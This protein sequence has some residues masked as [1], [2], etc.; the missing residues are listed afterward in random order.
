MKYRFYI[1]VLTF[2][3]C[4]SLY[5]QNDEQRTDTVKG[6][7]LRAVNTESFV[8]I[9]DG[10]DYVKLYREEKERH[11]LL[12]EKLKILKERKKSLLYIT[13]QNGERLEKE[14]K[15]KNKELL[16]KQQE[17]T[18]VITKRNNSELPKLMLELERLEVSIKSIE[19]DT[20]K[21]SN[22]LLALEKELKHYNED[23]TKLE[24]VKEK[25]VDRLL[26][27]NSSYLEN[28]FIE[29]TIEGLQRIKEQCRKYATD[30][31]VNAL[32]ARTDKVLKNKIIYDSTKQVIES[33]YDKVA[34]SDAL[35]DIQITE[36]INDVQRKDLSNVRD[37]LKMYEQ[38]LNAFKEFISEL[39][40]KRAGLSSYTIRDYNDDL[41][42]I[43]SRNNLE[44]RIKKY[45]L[46]VPYLSNKYDEYLKI[47]KKNPMK[48]PNLEA[49]ILN[50]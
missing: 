17:L 14:L 22:E 36:G 8:H 41:T 38:G 32:T 40:K 10:T 19:S 15:K 20:V 27:E 1:I 48:H 16:D 24:D 34:I 13:G 29:M 7:I 3:F 44:D 30:K 50:L 45:V 47:I 37:A 9:E 18:D 4:S 25:V 42:V 43:M 31:R 49:E 39:N 23:L 11:L 12:I 28:S 5:A 6:D 26:K 2:A 21:L 33:P 46:I 35:S